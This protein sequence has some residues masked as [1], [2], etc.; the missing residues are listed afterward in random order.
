MDCVQVVTT[1]ETREE[2]DR[3]TR[4]AVERRLAACAQVI[5]PLSSTYWWNGAIETASEWQCLLK[6]T[7]ARL[8]ELRAHLESEH[9]YQTPEIIA[10]PIVD[11]SAAYLDW[12]EREVA[13]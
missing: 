8:E 6:T 2:A 13:G 7:A 12:I 3:L 1:T 9:S 4:S 5:G 10:T 11:G